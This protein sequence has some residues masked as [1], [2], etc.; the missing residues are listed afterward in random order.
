[1]NFS[2]EHLAKILLSN[3]FLHLLSFVTL[4]LSVVCYYSNFTDYN[5]DNTFNSD[6]VGVPYLFK[7]IFKDGGYF[8]DWKLASAP[9][10]FPDMVLYYILYQIFELDFLTITFWFAIIQVL[11]IAALSCFVF[12]KLLTGRSK[13]FSWLVPLFYSFICNLC[14]L[15]NFRINSE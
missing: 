9:T 12:R 5:F 11:T 2:R 10:L 15:V 8:K 3:T 13:E 7:D 14:I 6:S 1:M 4:F